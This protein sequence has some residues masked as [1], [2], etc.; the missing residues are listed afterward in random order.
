MRTVRREIC[1]KKG[2]SREAQGSVIGYVAVYFGSAKACTSIRSAPY[3]CDASHG[4]V[5]R[6]PRLAC[7][8]VA[9]KSF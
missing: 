8:Q 6:L 2:T 9:A 7:K 1:V 5:M 4:G 3:N